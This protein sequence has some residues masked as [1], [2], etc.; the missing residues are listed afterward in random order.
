VHVR[1]RTVRAAADAFAESGYWATAMKHIAARA[2]LSERG[3]GHHFR[4][5]QELLTAVLEQH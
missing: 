3:L 4:R 2:D 5:K 1:D